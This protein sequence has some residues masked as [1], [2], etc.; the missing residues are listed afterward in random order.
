MYIWNTG[1]LDLCPTF[2]SDPDSL[3]GVGAGTGLDK[4]VFP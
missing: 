3:D 1:T 4:A 2:V